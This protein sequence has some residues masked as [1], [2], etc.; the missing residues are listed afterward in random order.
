[1]SFRFMMGQ[2]TGYI[3]IASA[4][5]QLVLVP[6]SDIVKNRMTRNLIARDSARSSLIHNTPS[7]SLY[8]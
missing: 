3:R 8:L 7:M 5:I 1:M 2:Y 6:M 4:S